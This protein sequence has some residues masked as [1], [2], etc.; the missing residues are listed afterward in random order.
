DIE[1][2]ELVRGPASALYGPNAAQG[3]LNIIT[4]SPF[5]SQGTTVFLA[6]GLQNLMNAGI[7]HAGTLS[8]DLGY[9]LSA[10]YFSANDWA[11]EDPVEVAARTA[12]LKPGVDADTLKIGN[13]KNTH[14][15]Y[16]VDAGLYYNLGENSMLQINTGVSQS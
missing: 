7:R 4:R 11:F 3:V 13:R 14:E 5:S 10:Q 15:R 9:K 2:I 8:D 12:A 1:R 6:G 16:N